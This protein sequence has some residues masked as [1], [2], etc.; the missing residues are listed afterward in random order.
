MDRAAEMTERPAIAAQATAPGEAAVA[1]VRAAGEGCLALLD[2]LAPG[3]GLSGMRGGRF[4]LA[5]IVSPETGELL[6]E[7]L[8]LVFRSPR[9]YTGEDAFEIQAHGGGQAARRI[10]D[11]LFAAGAAPAP[12]G[13]FTRRAFLNGKLDLAQ[14]E[15]VLDLIHARSGRAARMAAAQLDG[16]LGRRLDALCLSLVSAA[17][18]VEAM[19]DFPDD[20]LPQSMPCDIAERLESAERDVARL[21]ATWEEGRL[22]RDGAHVAIAGPPN[23]GKSTLFNLLSGR[24]HAI[25]SDRPGTTR[26]TLEES[27]SVRG[28]PVTLTDTAGLHDGTE[29]IE[30]EGIR[31]ARAAI[32]GADAV[33]AV[34]DASQPGDREWLDAIDPEKSLLLLNKSDLGAVA[35]PEDFP[36]RRA[37]AVSMLEPGTA[38]RVAGALAGLL[39]GPSGGAAAEEAGDVAISARH[40]TGLE[41]ARRELQRAMD[42][43]RNGDEE[44]FVPAAEHIR[45]ATAALGR[46]LGRDIDEATLDAIFSRFCVGK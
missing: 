25:V 24:D 5:R 33:L 17:A 31:R 23:A 15:A 26:D 22:L 4:R 10:L 13:E 16:A 46:I 11:A 32:G 3:Q 45:E 12:P 40:R 6:D 9:S 30:R 39:R 44:A 21:L 1:I 20:E 43:L 7:A 42:L 28:V 35:G 34:L 2:K 38:D 36:G 29:E 27:L 8:V 41:T 37:M 14:A 19:L 18:D